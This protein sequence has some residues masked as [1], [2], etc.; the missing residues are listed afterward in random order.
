MCEFLSGQFVKSSTY[1]FSTNTIIPK[2][3]FYSKSIL[4]VLE[5]MIEI[6]KIDYNDNLLKLLDD[7]GK[8]KTYLFGI[9]KLKI[10]SNKTNNIIII[11]K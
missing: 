11:D 3:I 8:T 10:K 7:D 5:G 2:D 9:D 4:I 6:N 1:K